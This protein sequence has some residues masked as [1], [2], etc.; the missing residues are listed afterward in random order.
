ML[1]YSIK[2]SGVLF[3]D[4][5]TAILN[6]PLNWLDTTPIGRIL[7][8]YTADF[9]TIDES[10]ADGLGFFLNQALQLTAIIAAGV[11]VSPLVLGFAIVLLFFCI[12]IARLYLPGAR[13]VKRIESITRSPIFEQFDSVT[14]GMATIRAYGMVDVYAQR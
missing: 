2:G 6:V 7:N 3:N 12:L 13:D 14:T 4:F 11:A 5:S 9:D 1:A 8:R 10:L